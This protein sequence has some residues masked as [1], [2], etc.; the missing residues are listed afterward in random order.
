[1]PLRFRHLQAL[2]AIVDTGTVT[3]AAHALA[4]SQPGVSNLIA[5]MEREVNIPLFDRVRG[6][7]VPTPEAMLLYQNIDT[8]MRGLEHVNQ[9][10]TDLQNKQVGQLQAAST[11]AMSFGLMPALIARFC[12]DK[13]NLSV[14]FQSQYSAKIQEWILSG[15]FEVGVCELPLSS[16]AFDA[17]IMRFDLVCA[18]PAGHDLA[19]H[20]VLTPALLED[21]PF[22]VMGPDHMTHRR[23]REAFQNAGKRW[24]VQVHTHL[25]RNK[26][27]FVREGMGVALMD[28]FTLAQDDSD[29]YITR[30]FAPQI[31]LDMAV[32]TSNRQTLSRLGHDFRAALID[33]MRLYL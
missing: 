6:R 7:L 31:Q 24:R 29:G 21:E 20:E 1:M 16:D 27:S 18:L 17:E 19:R 2:H 26:L 5:Q 32:I 25:F 9:A 8:V 15:L 10:V 4:I 22:I 23:T 11:H 14:S 3:A 28:P 12:K 30:P 13:P 33:E